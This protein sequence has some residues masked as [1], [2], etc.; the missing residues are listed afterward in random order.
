LPH[1]E[2]ISLINRKHAHMY[3]NNNLGKNINLKLSVT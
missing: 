3:N 1:L 2:F